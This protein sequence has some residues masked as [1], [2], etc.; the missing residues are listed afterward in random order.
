MRG[1]VRG[2]RQSRRVRRAPWYVT[3]FKGLSWW[4]GALILVPVI[5]AFR[6]GALG[7]LF[8][9]IAALSGSALARRGWHA[10][11]TAAALVCI[12]ALAW[13]AYLGAVALLVAL[14]VLPQPAPAVPQAPPVPAQALASPAAPGLPA[15][16]AAWQP[17]SC[18]ASAASLASRPAGGTPASPPATSGTTS[19]NADE[20]MLRSGNGKGQSADYS[21][22]QVRFSS[23]AGQVWI[24]AG[25]YRMELELPGDGSSAC[26]AHATA[27][28]PGAGGTASLT[29]TSNGPYCGP[30]NGTLTVYQ[31]ATDSTG[32]VTRLNATFSQV[33]NE[34]PAPRVGYIRYNATTP[35]PV[36]VAPSASLPIVPPADS[37]TTSAHPDEFSVLSDPG[38]GTG[39]G[40]P[41]DYVGPDI[42]VTGD[43]GKVYVS[44]GDSSDL[45]GY[46]RVTLSAP[47]GK[48]LVPGTYPWAASTEGIDASGTGFGVEVVEGDV[49]CDSYEGTFTVYQ[50]ATDPSGAITQLN[51]TFS[52]RCQSANPKAGFIRFNATAPTPVPLLPGSG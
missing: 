36:P 1:R 16:A 9:G 45:A 48:Q 37:G 25:P 7:G 28:A 38:G 52:E 40:Q 17:T 20:V 42:Q 35:T 44:V 43:W 29:V 12:D 51:A 31:F 22:A 27:F 26:G 2:E 14:R 13:G 3:V 10:L 30:A 18:A 5:L 34:L 41:F 49:A 21:G 4:Q 11:L 32:A 15:A 39:G 47:A 19:A 50:I 23:D 33:C 6:G 46:W 8:G 24:Y